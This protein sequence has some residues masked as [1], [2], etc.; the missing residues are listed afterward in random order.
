MTVR[1]VA[2]H[3]LH[4]AVRAVAGPAELF[5]R[6]LQEHPRRPW[7]LALEQVR[8]P[9]VLPMLEPV[10]RPPTQ[11]HRRRGWHHCLKAGRFGGSRHPDQAAPLAERWAAAPHLLQ[12]PNVSISHTA[13]F[14]N[15]TDV[16]LRN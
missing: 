10:P 12:A 8:L 1:A 16:A 14:S 4:W 9:R 11:S 13:L 3:H 6:P 5:W 15:I 2:T 7:L